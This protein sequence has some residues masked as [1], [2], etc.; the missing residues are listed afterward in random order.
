M[1]RQLRGWQ[2]LKHADG[3]LPAG[4]PLVLEEP[5]HSVGEAGAEQLRLVSLSDPRPSP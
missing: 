4:P 5:G 1:R 2:S 3:N